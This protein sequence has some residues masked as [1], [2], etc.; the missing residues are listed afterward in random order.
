MTEVTFDRPRL[1]LGVGRIIGGSVSILFRKLPV[2]ILPGFVLALIDLTLWNA[3]DWWSSSRTG[4]E[5]GWGS[6]E[7]IAFVASFT[8]TAVITSV[9]TAVIVQLAY[10][11]RLGRPVRMRSYIAATAR[12]LPA[13][14]VVSII[15]GVLILMGT[16]LLIIP[17]LW[18]YA[19]FCA[20]VPAVV[21]EGA[22]FSALR[23][24]MELTKNYRWPIVAVLALEFSYFIMI[25]VVIGFSETPPPFS[26][27]SFYIAL[28]AEALSDAIGYGLFGIAVALIFA[29]LKEIKEGVGVA[30]LVE[31][32]R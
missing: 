27:S 13:I 16:A 11:A 28:A 26:G 24:S 29:R 2:V 15:T 30:D 23:R 3:F 19:V 9:V 14:I 10:D 31:V 22:G 8:V 21:I 1:P 25:A 32:F 12:C 5:E 7:L 17:G 18:L 6:Y 20:A 4:P